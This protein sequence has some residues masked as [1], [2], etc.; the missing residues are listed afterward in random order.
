MYNILISKIC[1]NDDNMYWQRQF[2][3]TTT[4]YINDD[5][6]CWRRRYVLMTIISSMYWQ[7]QNQ[8]YVYKNTLI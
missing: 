1:I 3:L 8:Q 4:I 6:I 2:I 7:Q 5:N